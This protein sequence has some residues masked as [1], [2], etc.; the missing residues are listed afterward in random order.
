MMVTLASAGPSATSPSGPGVAS[1]WAE[2]FW[3]SAG[4]LFRRAAAAT[5]E[6]N[7]ASA[8]R[9]V[10]MTSL[11]R[12]MDLGWSAKASLAP[13]QDGAASR[14]RAGTARGLARHR[15][16]EPLERDPEGLRLDAR[17]RG[18]DAGALLLA[19]RGLG[20]AGLAARYR[21]L[22]QDE[23]ADAA[24]AV[25][26]VDAL[27]Q[28]RRQMLHLEREGALDAHDQGRGLR[29][30]LGIEPALPA[31]PFELHGARGLRQ[32]LAGDLRP[33]RDHVRGR[34]ALRRER[35]TEAGIDEVGKGFRTG[36]ARK[37]VQRP[38]W[39]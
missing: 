18:L 32:A 25:M 8:S 31:R 9:R 16:A 10:I 30:R 37:G 20:L 12:G 33:S 29:P 13:W 1:S 28:Q 3:A 14:L 26:G 7:S 36:H 21:P 22:L 6:P 19:H 2:T 24:P 11:R 34:K 38:R 27:D 17:S 15:R 4:K 5:A 23:A 39:P 35:R